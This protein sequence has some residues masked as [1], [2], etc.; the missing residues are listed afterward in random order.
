MPERRTVERSV[1]ERRTSPRNVGNRGVNT[2]QEDDENSIN[3]PISNPITPNPNAGD[4]SRYGQML[5]TPPGWFFTADFKDKDGDGIEDR[6]QM[7]PGQKKGE[8][9]SRNQEYQDWTGA[10]KPPTDQWNWDDYKKKKNPQSIQ[11]AFSKIVGG[12]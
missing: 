7:G 4:T 8:L 1:V 2:G 11:S 6:M 5:T 12:K 10:G 9:G 3:P